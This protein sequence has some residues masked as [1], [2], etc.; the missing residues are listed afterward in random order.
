MSSR[1]LSSLTPCQ[2]E[3][4]QTFW[5]QVQN[6]HRLCVA[7]NWRLNPQITEQLIALTHHVGENASTHEFACLDDKLRHIY[8]SS[9]DDMLHA[10]IHMYLSNQN[11]YREKMM[12]AAVTA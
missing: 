4:C 2:R 3:G 12:A 5:D 7:S 1:D 8:K 6:L 10:V 9:S 11:P